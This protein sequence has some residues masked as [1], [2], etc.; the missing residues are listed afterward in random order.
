MSTRKF[1]HSVEWWFSVVITI[2]HL[3]L[4]SIHFHSVLQLN[5]ISCMQWNP[6]INF[7]YIVEPKIAAMLAWLQHRLRFTNRSYTYTYTSAQHIIEWTMEFRYHFIHAKNLR[8]MSQNV[9]SGQ[10]HQIRSQ[11]W[12]QRNNKYTFTALVMT[13]ISQKVNESILYRM[14][15]EGLWCS[16]ICL[17]WDFE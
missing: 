16:F 4:L 13:V 2:I 7:I 17:L 1:K 5:R 6:F 9:S 8:Q 11:N 14:H 15:R 3:Y 10:R 12:C